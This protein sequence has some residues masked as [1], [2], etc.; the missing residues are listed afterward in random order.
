MSVEADE[1][2][3]DATERVLRASVRAVREVRRLR[4]ALHVMSVNEG[5]LHA[6]IAELETQL[7]SWTTLWD[8][9]AEVADR[10]S[11]LAENED[12]ST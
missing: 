6:R 8:D 12:L 9:L 4:E 10:A 2:L 7:A 5:K 11:Q 3:Q 1:A